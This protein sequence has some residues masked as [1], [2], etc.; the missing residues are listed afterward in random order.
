M[1]GVQTCA[2]PIS[3]SIKDKTEAAYRRTD[4]M[5]KR[6]K[7]MADWDRFASRST[8]ASAHVTPINS[9]RSKEAARG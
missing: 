8:P 2:L 7:M 1:T 6:A 3:H 4:L 9:K 5:E